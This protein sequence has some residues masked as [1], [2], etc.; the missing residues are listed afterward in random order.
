MEA[1]SPMYQMNLA[2]APLTRRLLSLRTMRRTTRT[3]WHETIT[4]S[5]KPAAMTVHIVVV[6]IR[7]EVAKVQAAINSTHF[8]SPMICQ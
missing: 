5:M 8:L 7:L 6:L 1:D 4:C 2:T 3:F